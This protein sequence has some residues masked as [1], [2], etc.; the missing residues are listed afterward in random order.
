MTAERNSIGQSVGE[1]LHAWTGAQFPSPEPIVGRY[2]RVE[3]L[4]PRRH[5]DDL[6]EANITD[7]TGANWTY[8]PYGPFATL[9]AYEAWVAS[10]S[11]SDDPMFF[12]IVDLETQKASGVASLLRTSTEDG[13]TEVG[14]INFSP[15]LQRTRASTESM[16]LLMARVFDVWGYRR[17]EWKC[18]A[19]NAPSMAAARRLGFTFEGTH[20]K[21]KVVKGRNRDTAW[22][23]I[24]DEE[25]PT[26]RARFQRWL[27]PT[28]FDD[29]GRQI[30]P[31][32]LA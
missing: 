28:N 4:D 30:T 23:S 8:L 1:V 13:S 16:Y 27:E 21:A 24:T 31:L 26:I 5:T 11:A 12:A 18:N 7:P 20:R 17:Y 3:P 22:F 19:L 25:W 32:R 29:A 2:C 15:L 14:H 10:V 6:F 9:D